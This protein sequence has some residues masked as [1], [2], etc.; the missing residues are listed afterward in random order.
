ML[1]DL[2]Q[3]NEI[4][5][6]VTAVVCLEHSAEQQLWWYAVGTLS[7]DYCPLSLASYPRIFGF[8]GAG[9]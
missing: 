8:T 2:A 7:L 9:H 6:E 1:R 5:G 4:P 3:C